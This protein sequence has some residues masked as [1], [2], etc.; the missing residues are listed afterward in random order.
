MQIRQIFS[1]PLNLIVF[2]WVILYLLGHRCS[3]TN[4]LQPSF[5]NHFLLS[6]YRIHDNNSDVK[7]HYV[8]NTCHLAIWRGR[9]RPRGKQTR[10]F[11]RVGASIKLRSKGVKWKQIYICTYTRQRYIAAKI[12]GSGFRSS[13]SS[14]ERN[15]G[16]AGVYGP[17]TNGRNI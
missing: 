13:K 16:C 1:L 6:K 14:D 17:K 2:S 8:Y 9:R 12:V 10:H 4:L 5:E 3:I 11:R 15:T 7:N